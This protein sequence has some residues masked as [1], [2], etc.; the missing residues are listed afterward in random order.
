MAKSKKGVIGRIIGVVLTLAAFGYIVS[1]IL[2][3]I[4]LETMTELDLPM[5]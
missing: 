1:R 4:D 5:E 2:A 3:F